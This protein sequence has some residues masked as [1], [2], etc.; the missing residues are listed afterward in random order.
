[1]AATA[2]DSHGA[3]LESPAKNSISKNFGMSI[4]IKIRKLNNFYVS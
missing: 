2:A 1:M 3:S 4:K